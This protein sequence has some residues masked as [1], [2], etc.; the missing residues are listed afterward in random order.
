MSTSSSR[1]SQ[2]TSTRMIRTLSLSLTLALT[3]CI[4]LDD[5]LGGGEEPECERD[6]DCDDDEEC[7]D[8]ECV[9]EDDDG[10]EGEG[11]GEGDAEP[12]PE[13]PRYLQ[14]NTNITVL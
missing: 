6:S 11:E 8:G 5:L 12:D 3:G 14:F 10:G 9:D 2:G 7:D 13:G 1:I 4:D